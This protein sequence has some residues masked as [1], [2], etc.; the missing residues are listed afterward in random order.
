MYVPFQKILSI[1][2]ISVLKS[3]YRTNEQKRKDTE[4]Q[5]EYLIFQLSENLGVV[6]RR[7]TVKN[8]ISAIIE[9]TTSSWMNLQQTFWRMQVLVHSNNKKSYF[10]S[11][12]INFHLRIHGIYLGCASLPTV[13]DGVVPTVCRNG[14]VFSLLQPN[15]S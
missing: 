1:P 9:N 14:I 8:S 3:R 15:I 6:H 7:G 13:Y 2:V 4:F 10:L 12:C 11:F 5:S